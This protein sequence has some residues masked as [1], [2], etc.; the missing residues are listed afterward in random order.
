MDLRPCHHSA[1]RSRQVRQNLCYV[2]PSSIRI[3]LGVVIRVRFFD[4]AYRW[5]LAPLDKFNDT[6]S[7]AFTSYRSKNS[8]TNWKGK[9]INS[10]LIS[11]FFNELYP[12]KV[13]PIWWNIPKKF[14]PI[15]EV[16]YRIL[17]TLTEKS[18]RISFDLVTFK[19]NL[20]LIVSASLEIIFECLAFVPWYFQYKS[21]HKIRILFK[22]RAFVTMKVV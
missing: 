18:N 8:L 13:N 9:S 10:F 12:D 15:N 4:S 3:A 11:Y 19:E 22:A 17:W 16:Y 6:A 20:W 14:A 2:N 5:I 7:S 21:S 1:Q